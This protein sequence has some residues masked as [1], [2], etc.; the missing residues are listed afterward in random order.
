MPSS[1]IMLI[2]LILPDTDLQPDILLKKIFEL[3]TYR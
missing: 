2:R 3:N 1:K